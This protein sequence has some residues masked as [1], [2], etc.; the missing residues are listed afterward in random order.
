M[1]AAFQLYKGS[2]GREVQKKLN[3]CLPLAIL[4]LFAVVDVF[5]PGRSTAQCADWGLNLG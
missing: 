2:L 1:L 3:S 4:V 5:V